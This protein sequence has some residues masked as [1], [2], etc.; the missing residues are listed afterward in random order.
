MPT[1][2]SIAECKGILS[3]W[4]DMDVE[5]EDFYE[6][7]YMNEHFPERLVATLL[8]L[9]PVEERRNTYTVVVPIY[10]SERY[11][12]GDPKTCP[13]LIFTSSRPLARH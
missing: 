4:N 11:A 7:W 2:G 12:D 5:H 6:Q 10:R 8:L 1:S 13:G 9:L 3:I